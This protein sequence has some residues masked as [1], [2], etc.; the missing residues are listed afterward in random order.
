MDHL[1][2]LSQTCSALAA[3]GAT[4]A[5]MDIVAEFEMLVTALAEQEIDYAVCGG[6]AVNIHG[7]VRATRDID[8]LI[9]REA[10]ANVCSIAMDLGFTVTSGPIPF[11]IGTK[12]ERE[13]HRVTKFEGTH[14][15]TLDLLLVTPVLEPVWAEREAFEWRGRIIP[16]VSLEGLATMKRLAGRHQDLA[17]LENLG[18]GDSREEQDQS[19]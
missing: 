9:R 7:H 6:F 19:G 16:V 1:D 12:E 13:I 5:D 17:D 11:D 3:F 15:L 4:L 14:F 10:L 8:L 2:T 18:V